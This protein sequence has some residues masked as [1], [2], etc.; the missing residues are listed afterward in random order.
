LRPAGTHRR[1][2]LLDEGWKLL[3]SG[4]ARGAADLF[5]RVLLQDPACSEARRGLAHAHIADA[6]HVRRLD[7]ELDRAQ[8]VAEA[9]DHAVARA[10]L[11]SIVEQGGDRDRAHAAL[12]R[13]DVRGGRVDDERLA[14]DGA[15][16]PAGSDLDLSGARAWTRPAL[17]LGCAFGFMLL[18][19]GVDARWD[20]LIQAL[21]GAPRPASAATP[22]P[23]AVAPLSKGEQALADARR[24]MEQGDAAGALRALD[25]VRPEEPAYPFAR[26]LRS[27]AESA[28]RAGRWN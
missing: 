6:E 17:A 28:L 27:Q 18:A 10:L 1:Q 21:E 25:G 24:L 2:S 7:A 20:G 26:Q 8:R 4:N 13:L 16:G 12:D 22:G 14:G 19:V 11:Q 5:G 9:G 23:P 3:S 15:S